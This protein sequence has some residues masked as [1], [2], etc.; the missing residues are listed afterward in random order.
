MKR[1]AKQLKRDEKRLALAREKVLECVAR[2]GL[3]AAAIA[4][5]EAKVRKAV[6]ERTAAL[7]L[8]NDTRREEN[9]TVSL[10]N[11]LANNVRRAQKTLKGVS[12][13]LA[14]F[15]AL[16]PKER[17]ALQDSRPD[18]SHAEQELSKAVA[19]LDEAYTTL[20]AQRLAAVDNLCGTTQVQLR[21]ARGELGACVSDNDN[22]E[23]HLANLRETVDNLTDLLMEE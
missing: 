3:L 22:N 17:H 5:A 6:E 21:V 15:M 2:R 13:S 14:N 18:T 16:R 4:S 20:G 11:E 12:S 8:Y 23:F 7:Q 10:L 9:E 19:E 1:A